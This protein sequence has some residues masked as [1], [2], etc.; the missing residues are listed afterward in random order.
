[1]E[2]AIWRHT[3]G[4]RQMTALD[5]IIWFADMIEPGRDYPEVARLRKLAQEAA[6]DEMLL[7]GLSDSILFVVQQGN[8]VHP[9]TVLARNEIL[10]RRC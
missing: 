1:M 4:G 7:A 5:K 3:V 10:L 8:L 2:Q 6:L 9:D